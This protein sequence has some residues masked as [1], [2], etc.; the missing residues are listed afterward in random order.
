MCAPV[1]SLQGLPGDET[2]NP[3][4]GTRGGSIPTSRF[5]GQNRGEGADPATSMRSIP[6]AVRHAAICFSPLH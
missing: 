5:R 1:H 2:G 6:F 4:T 3:S